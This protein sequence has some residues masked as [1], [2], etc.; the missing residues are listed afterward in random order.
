MG[1]AAEVLEALRGEVRIGGLW[2]HEETGNAVSYARDRRVRA[3]ARERGLS[4]HELPQNGVVRRMNNRDGWADT[5][6]ARMGA[7][8]LPAPTALRGVSLVSEGTRER[9]PSS[10]LRPASKRA[11]RRA[12]GPPAPR[13]KAF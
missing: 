3:W 7:A 1:E 10:A 11:F 13:W 4:F 2:A 9:T 12:S 5:W 6:E 8:P